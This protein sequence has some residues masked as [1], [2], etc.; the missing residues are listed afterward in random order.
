M[1]QD[2]RHVLYIFAIF[3]LSEFGRQPLP[4]NPIFHMKNLVIILALLGF[5]VCTGQPVTIRG[6][7]LNEQ[8]RPIS[9]ANVALFRASDTLTV[10]SGTASDLDG[11]YAVEAPAPGEYRLRVSYLGYRSVSLA[12]SADGNLNRDVRLEADSTAIGEVVVEGKRTVRSIDKTSYLFTKEQ[13]GKAS[14]GRE[15]VATLPN[16][17]VDRTTNALATIDGKSVLILI[18]GIKA[19][20]EEL[21]LIPADKV[22][23]VELYDVPPI[24]YMDDAEQVVNIRTR[25]LDTG[26]SGNLYGTLG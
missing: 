8:R 6:R 12:V 20:E 10:V 18:N 5:N 13:V 23:S 17:R 19:T 14:D 22:R 9:F 25:P 2:S 21:R 7:I 4:D 16:L 15:L 1:Q 26:W 24:R 11:R 3:V